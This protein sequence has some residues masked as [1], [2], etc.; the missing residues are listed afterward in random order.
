MS[1]AKSHIREEVRDRIAALSH[2]ERIREGESVWSQIVDSESFIQ[3]ETVVGYDAMPDEIDI[4]PLLHLARE[5]GKTG[6][7]IDTSPESVP[8]SLPDRQRILILVPGR[9]FSI[10]GQRIGRGWGWYD[11]WLSTLSHVQ[12]IWVCYSVQ[13]YETL[14]QD[15]YDIR[16]QRVIAGHH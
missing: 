4:S 8:P 12:T 1:R 3:A 14:P 6:I 13:L 16:M 2:D 7:M 9:A 5:R 15:E 11:R 10:S